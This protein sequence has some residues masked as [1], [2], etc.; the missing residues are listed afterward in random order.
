M[1][2]F[3]R[4]CSENQRGVGPAHGAHLQQLVEMLDVRLLRLLAGDLRLFEM[5]VLVIK[6]LQEERSVNGRCD[7]KPVTFT[8]CDGASQTIRLQ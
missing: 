2:V 6:C 3:C 8:G 4:V 1:F 7:S 5:D